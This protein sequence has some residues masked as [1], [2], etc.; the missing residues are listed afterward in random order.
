MRNQ[1]VKHKNSN[2]I[3][4]SAIAEFKKP[5]EGEMLE[6]KVV[7]I[8]QGKV[9][10]DLGKYGTGIIYGREFI[11]ARDL[12]KHI[13]P[14]DVVKVMVLEVNGDE[15]YIEL[16]LKEASRAL[17]WAKIEQLMNEDAVLELQ[18]TDY[19]KGGLILEYQGI[20]GF[21]PTS[22]L[23]NEHY[24]R[25]ENN[26]KESILR[27]LKGLV[28][29]TLSVSIFS[30]DPKEN[31]LIF[32]EKKPLS[33]A[34]KDI[35]AKYSVGDIVECEVSGTVDFGIFLKLEDGLEGLVHI[36]E[37]SWSLVEDT[38]K[39][40]KV[41]DKVKAKVISIDND[42]V[43]L[44][45]KALKENPWAKAAKKYKPGDVVRGTV[46]KFNKYG[47]LVSIEEGVAGLVHVSEFESGKHL[48]EALKLGESY[49]FKISIFDPENQKMI[50]NTIK[51]EK[52]E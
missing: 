40:Y 25:M 14:G 36:S 27:Q 13:S 15:G 10:V 50:L 4:D 24:P 23:S 21:L 45:I 5:D 20:K 38:S 51:E 12:I 1:I 39:L 32:S 30:V 11:N 48:K 47:A 17:L 31:K 28:G 2:P 46:I 16:S 43:S 42:K 9:L 37:L 41:G 34:K 33:G 52:E 22:Q 3:L 19:N 29:K 6:G 49:D 7:S 18:V 35:L 8:K 26:D 44:S